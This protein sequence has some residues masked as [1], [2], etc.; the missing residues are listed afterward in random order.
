[1]LTAR[2]DGETVAAMLFLKHGTS[3]TYHIGWT[4]PAGRALSAGNL[5]LTHA[6]ERFGEMGVEIVDL[7]LLDTET[8]P[9]LARF[10]L[11]TGAQPL[12]MGGTWIGW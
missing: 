12:R 6:A 2:L 8:A 7:G 3:A 11:G 4:S 1:M 10:K 9:G 5:L